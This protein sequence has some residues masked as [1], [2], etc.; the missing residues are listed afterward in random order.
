MVLGFSI[1]APITKDCVHKSE[2]NPYGAA[3]CNIYSDGVL[4][5]HKNCPKLKP[6]KH[7]L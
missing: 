2:G 6:L 1:P 3:Y 7:P 4:C 5:C